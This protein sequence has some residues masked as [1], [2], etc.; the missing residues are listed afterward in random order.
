MSGTVRPFSINRQE[1]VEGVKVNT[2]SNTRVAAVRCADLPR[3]DV[4]A[5]LV[6]VGRR[7]AE[8][9]A[10][11]ALTQEQLAEAMGLDTRELQRIEQ[12]RVNFTMRT[13]ARL[14]AALGCPPL[15][16]LRPTEAP[17][18]G[19]GRRRRE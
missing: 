10:A 12:G 7:V 19:P 6:E 11:R 3:V 17:D 13:L 5:L 8:L 16:L 15:E 14:A 18:A 1:S 2:G 4:G 9:R